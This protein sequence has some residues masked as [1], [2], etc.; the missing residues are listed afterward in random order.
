MIQV[1]WQASVFFGGF[2]DRN[3][4]ICKVDGLFDPED[5][6]SVLR[7]NVGNSLAVDTTKHPR[8]FESPAVML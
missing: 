7:R 4:F 1:F 2:L 5:E 3:A 8:R 6:G